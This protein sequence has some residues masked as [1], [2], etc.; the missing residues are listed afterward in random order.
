MVLNW[1]S[2]LTVVGL[3]QGVLLAAVLA[4]LTSG[5]LR[6]N[7]VLA[8]FVAVLSISLGIFFL[9]Y[10]PVERPYPFILFRL[11]TIHF[12]A[13]PLLYFYILLLVRP[14]Y[15]FS[16]RSGVHFLAFPIAFA[17]SYLMTGPEQF[18]HAPYEQ[19]S[20]AIK[21]ELAVR[22]VIGDIFLLAYAIASLLLLRQ[23]RQNIEEQFS[24]LE[25]ITLQWLQVLVVLCLGMALLSMVVELAG[26]VFAVYLTEA[27]VVTVIARVALLYC[28]GFMGLRQPLIFEA[29]SPPEEPPSATAPGGKKYLRSGLTES[30]VKRL[31]SKL[32]AHMA[33]NTSYRTPGLKV[34]DLAREMGV[35][36]NYLSQ[37]INSCAG[38]NF[39]E[40]INGYRLEEA[41]GLLLE[42]PKRPIAEIAL[43]VGFASQNAFNNHFKKHQ[44]QTPSAFRKDHAK[45]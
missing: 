12:W 5:N 36:E 45:S 10:T 28:I 20:A 15:F 39:F 14:D 32:Q 44:Q 30:D 13:G 26:L 2:L 35:R 42:Q 4:S 22:S 21:S 33:S 40:Y 38:R 23:H 6:A 18:Q 41:K 7:R 8:G 34:S 17:L 37:V 19:L 9:V 1:V 11:A 25:K 27:R 24:S 3:S 29:G 31:W 43:T 16:W